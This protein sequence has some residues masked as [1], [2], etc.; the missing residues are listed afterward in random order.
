MK[1]DLSV[2]ILTYNEEKHIQRC[3]ENVKDIATEI[4]IIDS[5]SQDKTVEIAKKNGA[6]VL[7][8]KWP[9][10]HSIQFNWALENCNIT[11]K[12]VMRLDADEVVSPGLSEEINV[13][14]LKDNNIK[15]Y[16]LKRGHIFLGK[17]MLHGGN[18]P[19]KLLRIW[20]YGFGYCE[21]K[22]MDEHIVLNGDYET[23]ILSGSFW[24]KNLNGIAWWTEK[25]NSYSTKEA[26]MQLRNK[27]YHNVNNKQSGLKSKNFL[28]YL[29]Y[30]KLPKSLR[31]FIYFNYRYFV[32]L[33]FLDGYQGLVWNFLQG[34]WY[35]FLVDVKVYEIEKKAKKNNLTIKEVVKN[36]HGIDL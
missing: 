23:K 22:L 18:Y 36:E 15:G 24:D 31:A 7:Q 17:K 26:I 10:N 3:I 19:I 20:E 9:D 6:I 13:E 12:W 14:L 11:T 8:N 5:F 27:S 1:N 28:K 35:R 30:E 16:I 25:H 33:G 29:V 4:F 34:F 21:D 2:L 32:R